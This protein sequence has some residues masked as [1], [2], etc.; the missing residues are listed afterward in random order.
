L[1]TRR[2][3]S[4]RARAAETA[5]EISDACLALHSALVNGAIARLD[6]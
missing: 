1:T 3:V 6:H 5:R 4:S 2:D